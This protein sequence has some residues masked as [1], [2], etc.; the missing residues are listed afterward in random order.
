[1]VPVH[2]AREHV[3]ACVE[4]V[5]R[6]ARGDWRLVLVDDASTDPELI[7][8]LD[9]QPSRTP[10]IVLLRSEHN[11]GFV[12]SANRGMRHA[13]AR[14]VLLLNSDTIVTRRFLE[15][16]A[17]CAYGSPDTGIVTPFTNNGTI[18]SIPRFLEPNEIPAPLSVDQ[19]A[20]L[21][22]RVSRK[23]RPEL[24][25]AVGFCMYVRAEVIARIGLFDEENFPRG[26]GEENDYSERAKAAGFRVRLC[27]DL[28]VA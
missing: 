11:R 26:Y 23:R 22:S 15:K 3:V 8:W 7:A 16:L 20:A 12:A 6:H 28:F 21:V 19:F 25:S 18:C 13:G 4:S 2:D 27:D 24:V 1:M 14:D 5:L 17:D 10:R 9:H